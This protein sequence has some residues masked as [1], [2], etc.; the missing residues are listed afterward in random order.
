MVKWYSMANKRTAY[1]PGTYTVHGELDTQAPLRGRPNPKAT[2]TVVVNPDGTGEQYSEDG[3]HVYSYS[4]AEEPA[5][6]LRAWN[7]FYRF[8]VKKLA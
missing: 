4:A 5:E 6:V 1:G 3:T 2:W 8:P 7:D